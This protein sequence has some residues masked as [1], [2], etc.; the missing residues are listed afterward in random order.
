MLGYI[1]TAFSMIR[2]NKYV[3]Y[4]LA[5]MVFVMAG[6]WALKSF[7]NKREQEG[8]LKVAVVAAA[9]VIKNMERYREIH[10]EVKR[11][12]MSERAARLRDTDRSKG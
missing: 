1:F 6:V 9:N 3:M 7:G 12:P 4:G 11:L 10:T 5:A 2:S 8:A